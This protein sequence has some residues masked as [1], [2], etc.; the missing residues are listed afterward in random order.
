MGRLA[1]LVGQTAWYGL[2]SMLG[3]AIQF[4]LVPFYTSL[5]DAA[6][7][8]I[9]TELYSY[10]AFLNIVYLYGM[11]TTYFRQVKE[12]PLQETHLFRLIQSSIFLSTLLFSALLL[13]TS[14]FLMEALQYPGKT[15]YMMMLVLIMAIDALVVIPFA[16]LRNFNKAPV[17]AFNRLINIFLNILLNLF[18]LWLCPK[19]IDQGYELAWFHAEDLVSY[20]FLS[21]VLA[22]AC[23]IPLF[24]RH[25]KEYRWHWDGPQW[26]KMMLY[27][28]P[29]MVM[30]LAGM[31]NEVMDRILLK[32]WLPVGF[33]PQWTSQ[34]ALGIYGAC[35]KLSMFMSLAV[36]A[37]RFAG[38]PFFFKQ[39]SSSDSRQLFAKVTKWF[40]ICC[41]L[42]WLGVSVNLFWIAPIFIRDAEM[43][44][45]LEVVPWLLLANLFLGV[46]Y[47]LSVWFKLS[48]TTMAGTWLGLAGA[49]LTLVLNFFLIPVLGFMGSA[50]ATLGCYTAM[51]LLSFA[52]GQKAY[53]IPYDWKSFLRVILVSACLIFAQTWIPP[54]MAWMLAYSFT[55][56]LLFLLMV[57]YEYQSELKKK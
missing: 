2:S 52:W 14:S 26:K 46:Y 40:T 13:A 3:R 37:F 8:G 22:N 9:V 29:L 41:A 21:N 55:S 49:V 39:S 35:Y 4:L 12:N 57:Y 1:S 20:I 30:G 47:N 33:Y 38:E 56:I 17:F 32:Y 6:E 23:W 36:Q 50:I 5:L 27:A 16:R 44:Q 34:Q 10:V 54:H 18:F 45:G 25:W 28:M 11:E 15:D 53:P 24:Y 42:L 19:L 31:V 7:Y 51:L 43:R 48:D